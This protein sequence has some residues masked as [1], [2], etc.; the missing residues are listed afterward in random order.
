MLFRSSDVRTVTLA[1][2]SP[3]SSLQAK[4]LRILKVLE[5]SEKRST[6]YEELD[7]GMLWTKLSSCLDE[8]AERPELQSTAGI[9]LPLIESLL[10]VFGA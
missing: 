6:V 3:A 7:F 8:I 10:V 4:L 9:L 5:N 1:K 2:F